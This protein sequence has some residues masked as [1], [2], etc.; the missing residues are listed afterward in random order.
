M[1]ASYEKV[2]SSNPAIGYFAQ[3]DRYREARDAGEVLAP[4]T[5]AA[6]MD[7]VITNSTVNGVLQASLRGPGPDHRRQRGADLGAGDPGRHAADHGG[8]G[9]ALGPGRPRRL[10]RDPQREGGG[11]RLGGGAPRESRGP[12]M[13][14]GLPGCWPGCAGTSAS[15]AVSRAG[16]PT[17]SGA[18][19]RASSR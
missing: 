6:Q 13:T 16:T 4:A 8:P 5:D 18:P 12:A 11:L 14:A 17:W 1:T 15:S 9:P 19:G 10:L 3:A 2:F 7:T